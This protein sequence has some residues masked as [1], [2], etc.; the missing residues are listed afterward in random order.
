MIVFNPKLYKYY[1][2]EDFIITD[3][4]S[5]DQHVICH[6]KK[7]FWK[8]WVTDTRPIPTWESTLEIQK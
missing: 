2:D 4:R 8:F 5:N 6:V 7:L 3:I 1:G